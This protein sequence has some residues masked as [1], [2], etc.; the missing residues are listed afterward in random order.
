MLLRVLLGRRYA[1]GGLDRARAGFRGS[2]IQFRS[3]LWERMSPA[4]PS[5]PG[6]RPS[7]TEQPHA[8]HVLL[9]AAMG[10]QTKQNVKRRSK[11]LK[12]GGTAA[13]RQRGASERKDKLEETG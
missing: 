6:R 2:E 13:Q 10:R 4:G 5:Y 11:R 7:R 3:D 9:D 1:H 12:G 8:A